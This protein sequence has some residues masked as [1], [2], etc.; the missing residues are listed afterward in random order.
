VIELIQNGDTGLSVRS[1]L[2]QMVT[3]INDLNP[4]ADLFDSFLFAE[5]PPTTRRDGSPLQIGDRLFKPSG[6]NFVWSGSEWLTETV[7]GVA[8]R[9][10]FIGSG[11][12]FTTESA[13]LIG[14][15]DL[16]ALRVQKF[17]FR[18]QLHTTGG[19][20]NTTNYWAAGFVF[21]STRNQVG[22]GFPNIDLWFP[23]NGV[24]YPLPTINPQ[25]IIVPINQIAAYCDV[26]R[27][28]AYLVKFGSVS[29]IVQAS[30]NL[31][32][33]GIHP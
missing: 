24:D 31:I 12:N 30:F 17:V 18:Y 6:F 33:R 14:Y 13:T 32:T 3:S 22:A 21:R 27:V 16:H 7:G 25:K 1:K 8:G 4:R 20:E 11:D 5:T 2:N 23:L 26:A 28:S 15:E 19:T 10:T 9:F 29:S